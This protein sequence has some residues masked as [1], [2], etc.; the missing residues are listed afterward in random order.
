LSGRANKCRDRLA[1]FAV[2]ASLA[3]AHVALAQRPSCRAGVT[4]SRDLGTAEGRTIY[5]E[6]V[7]LV[8][9]R[10]T[11]FLAGHPNYVFRGDS[12][13]S[14]DGIMGAIWRSAGSA[15]LVMSP[16]PRRKI[17]D[18]RLAPI[19]RHR[20]AAVFAELGS[21]RPFPQNQ[22]VIDLWFAV[23]DGQSWTEPERLPR[24]PR[25]VIRS[26][27]ASSLV[28]TAGALSIAYP[29]DSVSSTLP[30]TSNVGVFS[31]RGGRWSLKVI[32]TFMAGAVSLASVG[33]HDLRLAVVQPDT[34]QPSDGGSVF[35]YATDTA[36]RNLGKAI[37]GGESYTDNPVMRWSGGRLS[38]SWHARPSNGASFGVART[39][40]LTMPFMR[41]SPAAMP[42]DDIV[43]FDT[44]SMRVTE[45]TKGEHQI[46]ISEHVSGTVG[47]AP[48]REF[49]IYAD[50]SGTP[51]LIARVPD[52]F[53]GTEFAAQLTTGPDRL[54]IVGPS[55]KRKEVGGV[56]TTHIVELPLECVRGPE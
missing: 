36:W 48:R 40:R 35:L 24:P 5:I 42:T 53:D 16:L 44:T 22:R 19:A 41:G 10:G 45:L 23:F 9:D 34:S 29:L 1:A 26:S 20:W 39:T 18:V 2:A 49:R 30:Q 21:D 32:P 17:G 55:L 27:A 11:I 7:S 43:T 4:A 15:H 46:W 31:R 52:N 14:R 12:L 33:R 47:G 8:A 54:L 37:A 3:S 25:G 38:L 28:A 50:S 51:A 13:L 56:L 6:P